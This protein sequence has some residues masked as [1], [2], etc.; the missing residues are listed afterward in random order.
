MSTRLRVPPKKLAKIIR[1]CRTAISQQNVKNQLVLKQFDP[2]R[3]NALFAPINEP[4]ANSTYRRL[5]NL[6]PSYER[7]LVE[8]GRA[9]TREA[10]RGGRGAQAEEAVLDRIEYD[11]TKLPFLCYHEVL[12]ICLGRPWL[13]WAID[14]TSELVVGLYLGFEQV[15]DVSI[16][17][18]LRSACLPKAYLQTE[19][20][21][22]EPYAVGG[23]PRLMVFDNP[24]S[25][26]GR[27]VLG[28]S[29]DLQNDYQFAPVRTGWFKPIVEGSFRTLNSGLLEHMPGFIMDGVSRVDYDPMQNAC[30]GFNALLDLIWIWVVYGHARGEHK[31]I[32][33][34]RINVWNAH[35]AKIAPHYLTSQAEADMVFTVIRKGKPTSAIDHNGISF[36]DLDYYSDEVGVMR[37]Q[38]G[39]TG[40][41]WV[42]INPSNL[43][44]V[45]F[46]F[47][48]QGPW[49]RAWSKDPAYTHNLSLAQHE[50]IRKATK[51]LFGQVNMTRLL[52][53]RAYLADA[54]A[55]SLNQATTFT[56]IA[57]LC[58]IMG[59]GSDVITNRVRVD[60]TI[61]D[62]SPTTGALVSPT[63]SN[64]P[65]GL[66][67]APKQSSTPTPETEEAAPSSPPEPTPTPTPTSAQP[68]SQDDD[69]DDLPEFETK[70]M[71]NPRR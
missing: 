45:L 69:D 24:M 71:H 31:R 26:H 44:Y 65:A 68:T 58:R 23:I 43:E 28:I 20:R 9:A 53:G 48:P 13:A 49:A 41:V 4:V 30:I 16:V 59:I 11:E 70:L 5:W 15:S 57:Q 27:T 47:N 17:S 52:E 40:D 29:T 35:A 50:I 66:L 34:S 18:A 55:E 2:N 54:I 46:S 8:N 61:P 3:D 63:L 25:Q 42:R 7:S 37:R 19:F 14:V 12:K 67:P 51:D 36:L 10:F 1:E 39:A 6:I 62:R 22:Q 64:T 38:H 33:D 60:G 56:D 21:I 32:K